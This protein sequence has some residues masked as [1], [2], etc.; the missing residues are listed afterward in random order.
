MLRISLPN[1]AASCQLAAAVVASNSPLALAPLATM[2]APSIKFIYQHVKGG[3]EVKKGKEY[4]GH[5]ADLEDAKRA[6]AKH[7]KVGDRRHGA[8]CF[9]RVF[10]RRDG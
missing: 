6:L 4:F 7:L 3:Y 8:A 1:A 10:N 5:F 9:A 2:S